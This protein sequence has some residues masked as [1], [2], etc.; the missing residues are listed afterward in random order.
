MCFGESDKDGC[1]AVGG[2]FSLAFVGNLPMVPCGEE[3][4][5]SWHFGIRLIRYRRGP[6]VVRGA[7]SEAFGVKN[8]LFWYGSDIRYRKPPPVVR[9]AFSGAPGAQIIICC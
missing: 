1:G 7:F 5:F 3:P 8:R 6:P 2:F 9:G 4:S